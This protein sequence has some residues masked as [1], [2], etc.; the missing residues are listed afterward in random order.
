MPRHICQNILGNYFNEHLQGQRNGFQSGGSMEYWKVLSVTIAGRQEKSLNFDLDD[1]LL[2]V[3]T[4]KLF[5]FFL[6]FSFFQ[7]WPVNSCFRKRYE[8]N[9]KYHI[10]VIVWEISNQIS[11]FCD[12][13][14]NIQSNIKYFCDRMRNI[15]SNIIFLWSYEKCPS[16]NAILITG[17]LETQRIFL[18]CLRVLFVTTGL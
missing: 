10:F 5:L 13:M 15:Q 8:V 3:F 17:H 1:N 11:Y 6:C 18:L 14:R 7:L 12:R 16:A 2:I 4:L 9:I